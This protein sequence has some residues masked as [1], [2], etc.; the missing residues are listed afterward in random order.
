MATESLP[1]YSLPVRALG[2]RDSTLRQTLPLPDPDPGPALRDG[3]ARTRPHDEWR[4]AGRRHHRARA[5]IPARTLRSADRSQP[6]EARCEPGRGDLPIVSV[7]LSAPEALRRMRG[8]ARRA[9]RR[10][11]S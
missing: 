5:S 9:A 8:P 10:A 7:A 2:A 6:G 3:D 11:N 4:R 1:G